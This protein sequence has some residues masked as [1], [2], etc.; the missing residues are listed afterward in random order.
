M[1]LFVELAQAIIGIIANDDF[2][3]YNIL[4]ALSAICYSRVVTAVTKFFF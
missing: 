2:I 4:E 3:I 1:T